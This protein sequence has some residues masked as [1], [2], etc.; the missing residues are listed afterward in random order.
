MSLIHPCQL[1]AANSL[2]DLVEQQRLA[3]NL[4]GRPTEWIP[5]N[6]RETIKRAQA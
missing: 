3:R 6:Y 4:V 2:D 1:R 5:W